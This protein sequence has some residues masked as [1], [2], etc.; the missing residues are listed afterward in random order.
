MKAQYENMEV[1]KTEFAPRSRLEKEEM[2][3][4][5]LE[6]A[7]EAEFEDRP[8]FNPGEVEDAKVTGIDQAFTGEKAVSAVVVMQ[9]GEVVEKVHAVEELQM[10][11]IPGLLAFR[12]APAITSALQKLGSEPD[13][14]VLDG[15]GRIHFREAGIAAHIGVLFDVLA[16]GVAKNLLCGKPHNDTHYMEEGEKVPIHSDES[17]ETSTN[18]LIGYAFQSRQYPN[19]TK[20]NPLYVSP[21]HQ[22]SAETAVEIVKKLGGDYKLPEPTVM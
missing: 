22:L 18:Q 12:E 9:E 6:I 2:K 20:I 11:Y 10:P 21:G 3:Q 17:L 1:R 19:S 5:Q 8:C 14:L 7:S 4:I 15:S 13:L 16:I